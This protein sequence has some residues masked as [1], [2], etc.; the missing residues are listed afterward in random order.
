MRQAEAVLKHGMAI[1]TWN[2]A[3]LAESDQTILVEGNHYFPPAAVRWDL[4]R[5]S[6]T[7]S[8]CHWKGKAGY[9]DVVVDG[10]TNRD[11]AWTYPEPKSAASEIG[12][13]VAFWRGVQVA[14]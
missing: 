4:L 13:Y 8:T 10:S 9:Y 5:D 11:A 12:G 14:R 7:R 1:A 3:V 6:S 2:G